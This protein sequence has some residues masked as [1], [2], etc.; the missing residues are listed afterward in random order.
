VAQSWTRLEIIVVDDGSN[1]DTAEKVVAVRDPRIRAVT[2][3]KAGAA[4]ARNRGLRESAGNIIQFLDADDL[5]S[6]DKIGAQ[7]RALEDAP[8][9]SL[10]SC[11]WRPFY[12]DIRDARTEVHPVWLERDPVNWLVRSLSGQGMMQTA[13]WL[14][15]RA[16]AQ[17]AGDWNESLSLHD[18]GE[19]FAR[20]LVNAG[21]NIFVPGPVVFYRELP[22][23]LS[24]RR[25]RAA[26]ESALRVCQLRHET[27]IKARDDEGTRIAL[28]TTY[29]QFAYEFASAAPDLSIAALDAIRV[30]GVPPA[31]T[32]GGAG[33]RALAAVAGF[34]R[35]LRARNALG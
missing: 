21:R 29:A 30:L 10:A 27:L 23:S 24:R 25:S 7:V 35:A 9:Q 4:A 20:V 1:D 3:P 13:G 19:Y 28:A 14:I 15:P 16:V 17:L 26:I 22:Q 5:L 6:P 2:Q 31:N 34:R 18:D 33:F 8:P 12:R 11:E 32:I